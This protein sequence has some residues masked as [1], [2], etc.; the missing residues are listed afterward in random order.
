M[1]KIETV[2][3]ALRELESPGVMGLKYE[4]KVQ[5]INKAILRHAPIIELI[6][7][8][9]SGNLFKCPN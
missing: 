9:N 4:G 1:V 5:P 8:I 7:D 3:E 6:K 2:E